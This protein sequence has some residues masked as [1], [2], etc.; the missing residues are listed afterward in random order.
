MTVRLPALFLLIVFVAVSSL[1]AT[2]AWAQPAPAPVAEQAEEKEE[3]GDHW[4]FMSWIIP[5][6]TVERAKARLGKSAFG[7]PV[8]KVM[9]VPWAIIAAFFALILAFLAG[10]RFRD[11]ERAIRPHSRFGLV[12]VVELL[13]EQIYNLAAGM[14][15]EKWV[16]ATF[17]ILATLTFFIGICNCMGA[18]PGLLPPTESLNTTMPMAL[19]V[20]FA[21]HYFGVR[22]QGVGYLKH[23]LGPI[24]HPAALPLMLLMV[25]IE[26]IGH[27]ARV[28]SLSIR[29]MGNMVADHTVLG[30]FLGLIP[31]V[32]PIP[33]QILGLLIALVQTFVFLI[34]STV[35]FSMAVEHDEH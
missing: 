22:A 21:T 8:D 31:F 11:T 24:S 20:F 1:A 13:L 28:L 14:M 27:L 25:I 34:L 30:I 19:V 6:S 23:F 26:T 16:K 29:L 2:S 12:A 15:E 7:D 18:I 33:I 3:K 4:S 32:V 10:R 9:H 35:Y 5:S 17:P